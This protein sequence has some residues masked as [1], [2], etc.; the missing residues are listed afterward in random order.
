[1]PSQK[2]KNF[3]YLS[4]DPNYI[5]DPEIEE[6][7]NEE[8]TR[9]PKDMSAPESSN[10]DDTSGVRRKEEDDPDAMPA[11]AEDIGDESFYGDNPTPDQS[12]TEEN[13]RAVGVTYE[14]TEDLEFE[15][16][17]ERRDRERF[18]L[19]PHSKTKDNSI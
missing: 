10:A 9:A 5:P 14:D 19:D 6:F 18:E 17:I 12:D 3:Q 13:A 1:M 2:P 16:K 8:I 7:M 11:D 4:N 15:D